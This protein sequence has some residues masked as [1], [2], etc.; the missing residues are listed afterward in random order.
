MAPKAKENALS[1]VLVLVALA[2]TAAFALLV[3]ALVGIAQLRALVPLE[4]R[5]LDEPLRVLIPARN[6][7]RRLGPT[8]DALLEDPAES[9]QVVVYDDRSSDGTAALLAERARRDPRLTVLRGEEEPPLGSF[10]KPVALSR[11]LQ[12]ADERLG[13]HDGVLLFLDADVVLA[14]GTLGGVVHGLRASGADALSGVPR[15]VCESAIEQLFVPVLT[16]LVGMRHRPRAVHDERSAVAFLNGQLIVIKR[17]ALDE[18]GGFAAVSDAVLEDVALARA[19]KSAG[20]RL[21]LAA[22]WPHART[23]MY[24]SWREIDEGFG[25]NA[26]PL[27]GG[28]WRTLSSALAALALACLPWSGALAAV[29]HGPS[30]LLLVGGASLAL[31]LASQASMRRALALPL[32]PILVLPLAYGGAAFVLVRAA[33]RVM[34][35]GEVTWRGRRYRASRR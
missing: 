13:H 29:A 17:E 22:L 28:P 6:E 30:P 18:V 33:L 15:F 21:R 27:F 11:A 19:L 10:G 5:D 24:T 34:R 16:S 20:K 1:L 25:K 9:L 3:G 35:G 8:L 23:R 14:P 32:W 12:K 4:R 31:A 7:E 2:A 26:V